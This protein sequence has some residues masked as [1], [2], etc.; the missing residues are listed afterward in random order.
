ML[1]AFGVM[2][3]SNHCFA[4]FSEDVSDHHHHHDGFIA[5][6]AQTD[7]DDSET[8]ECSEEEILQARL[9]EDKTPKLKQTVSVA[10]I[11]PP[12]LDIAFIPQ[13]LWYNL[14]NTSKSPPCCGGSLLAF[15]TTVRLLL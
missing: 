7:H 4:L 6:D 5:H 14:R 8:D 9:L 2:G 12:S 1:L 11:L 3:T 15:N 13:D 10:A